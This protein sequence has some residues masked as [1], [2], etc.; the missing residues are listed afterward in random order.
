M[1]FLRSLEHNSTIC[2]L[3]FLSFSGMSFN[4]LECDLCVFC[5]FSFISS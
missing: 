1:G 2:Y 4:S 5:V 3:F